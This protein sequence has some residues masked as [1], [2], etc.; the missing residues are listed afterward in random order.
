MTVRALAL[1]TTLAVLLLTGCG[2]GSPDTTASAGTSSGV[3]SS[4]VTSTGATST[5]AT[6]S[7][8]TGEVT[9]LAAAS[10]T[11]TLTTLAES[12]ETANPGTE[13][14]LS[15][16]SS[17]TLARQIAQGAEAD[18][19]A[20][21]GTAALRQLGEVRPTATV[22]IARN[23]LE[24]ATPPGNPAKVTGLADLA[25]EDVDVV[26]C[27][28]TVPCGAA[29][30]QVL[31]RA[32]VSAHVVSREVDVTATLAKVSLDEADA[33][34]V[35]H[36]DVVGAKDAAVGVEIPAGQNTTL[37]YPLARFGDEAA[38]T[39]FA[40]YVAGP[41]GQQALQAAGFLAP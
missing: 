17:T 29:A 20:S 18:L 3:T 24:I 28:A 10:L 37:D 40:A 6:S 7:A 2:G 4:G 15:F 35:Y 14:R 30:D 23:T 38:T 9:V 13:I 11:T 19:F 36:S 39:A 32:G 41:E 33:A 34:V 22:T 8:V 25:R 16:G 12:F 31:G 5:G 21:A 1:P 27:A 26:L